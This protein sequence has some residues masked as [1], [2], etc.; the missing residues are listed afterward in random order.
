MPIQIPVFDTVVVAITDE[1]QWL[2]L[3][4]VQ[5]NSVTGFKFAFFLT[6]AAEGFHELAVF[7]ELKHVIGSITV[8]HEDRTIRSDGQRA[9]T[10][11]AS[12]LV[13]SCFLRIFNGP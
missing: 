7:V 6:G 2:G 1:Q 9:G 12:V 10:K 8:S 3:P 4:G 13:D 11:S 5:R